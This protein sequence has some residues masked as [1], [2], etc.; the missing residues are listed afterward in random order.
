MS[1]KL[2]MASAFAVVIAI[3]AI[4]AVLVIWIMSIV[5]DEAAQVP[6]EEL[7]LLAEFDRAT[8]SI[9]T[10]YL[11]SQQYRYSEDPNYRERFREVQ[12]DWQKV[13]DNIQSSFKRLNH[14]ELL[15]DFGEVVKAEEKFASTFK[16]LVKLNSDSRK[17]VE[18]FEAMEDTINGLLADAR[19]GDF[20]NDADE[21]ALSTLLS[22]QLSVGALTA[23]YGNVAETISFA[24]MEGN[25]E[26]LK[27]SSETLERLRDSIDGRKLGMSAQ[28]QE[29]L[30][31]N[32][33]GMK[34]NV[35]ELA[36]V[37][38]ARQALNE[39]M[40]A[41]Y[42]QF[43]G[44]MSDLGKRVESRVA[45]DATAIY[46]DAR[47]AGRISGAGTLAGLLVA[48][49]MGIWIT[50][51]VM[52]QLGRDPAELNDLANRQAKGYLDETTGEDR[53]VAGA[54]QT[55]S[56]KLRETVGVVQES[57]QGV[58]SIGDQLSTSSQQLRE[59]MSNQAERASMIATAS[60]QMSQTTN[61]I[62]QNVNT[63]EQKA[64]ETLEV[65]QSGGSKVQ[66]SARST[67]EILS[68]ATEASEQA[69]ALEAKAKEVQ[70]V[71]DIIS[72]IADQT[73]LLAL[74]AAIEAARA[75][76]T[77]R[78]F[79]VVADEVRNL[80]VRS[81]ESTKQINDIIGGMQEGVSNVVGSMTRVTS[82]AQEGHEIAKDTATSFE[83]IVDAMRGL[84]EHVAQNAAAIDEMSSTAEQMS[85]D[86]ESVSN[87]ATESLKSASHI[88]DASSQLVRNTQILSDSVSFF[89]L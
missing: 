20:A 46:N 84:Q 1:L 51:T 81:A 73:N 67:Q 74:N 37:T 38:D 75:G 26:A 30:Q 69:N 9:E 89:K 42:Q 82:S 14:S 45:E 27:S 54:M 87:I 2:K 47:A 36:A 57:A 60:T 35:N 44:K 61:E 34:Q 50:R 64:G 62:A 70:G 71:V 66:E 41:S 79:A 10:L 40:V 7:P 6:Q 88:E 55:V 28:E 68:H 49:I 3:N 21:Q 18:N 77:G 29:T 32:L 59:G 24:L 72:N 19:I 16:R 53:G 23:E 83:G 25:V 33:Q 12:E 31:A 76:E 85:S 58:A 39:E 11:L 63:V 15:G 13:A 48:V 78:G 22:R 17:A 52:Q 65:A 43:I 8:S 56:R 86:I 80:S 4:V 5:R